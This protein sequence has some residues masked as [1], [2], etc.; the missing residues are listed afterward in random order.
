MWLIVVY[1]SFASW[2]M[3]CCKSCVTVGLDLN[4]YVMHD[5]HVFMLKVQRFSNDVFALYFPT[6]TWSLVRVRVCGSVY[7][8]HSF[9]CVYLAVFEIVLFL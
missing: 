5:G 3:F 8:F 1:V 9:V 7:I 2:N 6:M 4:E